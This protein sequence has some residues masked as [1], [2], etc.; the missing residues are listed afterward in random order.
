MRWALVFC[1]SDL[2]MSDI[3][4]FFVLQQFLNIMIFQV[5]Q[6]W[7]N[8][9]SSTT[10]AHKDEVWVCVCECL[11]QHGCVQWSIGCT[12]RGVGGDESSNASLIKP[13]AITLLWQSNQWG[14]VNTHTWKRGYI[15]TKKKRCW[16]ERA[17]LRD[18][19]WQLKTRKHGQIRN[20]AIPAPQVSLMLLL[21]SLHPFEMTHL[22]LILYFLTCLSLEDWKV[23]EWDCHLLYKLVQF[24][25]AIQD[26]LRL[27]AIMG[28]LLIGCP[29]NLE[30]WHI[31]LNPSV[32][33][34][35]VESKSEVGFW[36]SFCQGNS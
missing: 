32:L 29:L 31:A 10:S 13:Q 24:S 22:L 3:F 4:S 9:S 18:K 5:Y 27:T 28:S 17:H 30:T 25:E 1:L 8:L 6:N 19:N 36:G 11:W 16:E 12:V 14:W 7:G 23:M 26:H 2:A 33:I 34:C 15:D 21:S 20:P 35:D